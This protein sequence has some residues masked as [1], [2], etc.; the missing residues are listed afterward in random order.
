MI[1]KRMTLGGKI[2][3][4]EHLYGSKDGLLNVP[5]RGKSELSKY[6]NGLIKQIEAMSDSL[7]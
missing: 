6:P 7:P 2:T 4:L 1:S 3:H 5:F